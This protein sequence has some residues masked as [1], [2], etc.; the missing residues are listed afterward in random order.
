MSLGEDF[1]NYS[2]EDFLQGGRTPEYP[3]SMPEPGALD[4]QVGKSNEVP[5]SRRR[6]F[7]HLATDCYLTA[8]VTSS[9]ANDDVIDES[10]RRANRFG[11]RRRDDNNNNTEAR[12]F[13]GGGFEDYLVQGMSSTIPFLLTLPCKLTTE[14]MC[15]RWLIKCRI[16]KRCCDE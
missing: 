5:Y 2:F 3:A 4:P 9:D 6:P 15:I 1:H 13:D 7:N 8:K 10:T 16:P 12:W 14:H 11:A